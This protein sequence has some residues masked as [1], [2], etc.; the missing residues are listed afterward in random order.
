MRYLLSIALISLCFSLS[1]QETITYPYNPDADGDSFI[2]VSDILEGVATYDTEFYPLS[3]QIDSVNLIDVIQAMQAAI[4]ALET[5]NEAQGEI[6]DLLLSNTESNAAQIQ[7]LI[8]AGFIT[9]EVDPIASSAGYITEE[10]DPV[11]NASGY[12][13]EIWVEEQGYSTGSGID[14]LEEYLSVDDAN[15]TV[16]IS[17]A[18]LQV[19]SGEGNTGAAANGTGNIIIGYDEDNWSGDADKSGSHNLV[20]GIGHTYSSFGGIVV[21]YEN[22]ITGHFSSVSGGSTNTASGLRSSVSGGHG[23]TAEGSR[24]SVSGGDY[25]TASG[26]FSSVSAG[27]NNTASGYESSVSG[28]RVNTASGEM[29]SVSGGNDNTASGE[30]SSVSGGQDNTASGVASSVS[31]GNNNTASVGSSSVSGGS[32]NTA[33]GLSSSVSGG[34]GNNAFG[35]SSSVSGDISYQGWVE[36]QGYLTTETDPVATSAGYLTTETDPVAMEAMPTHLTQLSNW[37][38]ADNDG[39]NDHQYATTTDV[40][41]IARDYKYSSYFGHNNR[42]FS[43]QNFLDMNWSGAWLTGYTFID[44]WAPNSSFRYATLHEVTFENTWLTGSDFEGANLAYSTW[45]NSFP[46]N[47][48][49]DC[50]DYFQD[51]NL[52]GADF[53]QCSGYP[54]FRTFEGADMSGAIIPD[55]WENGWF[56]TPS[57]WPDGWTSGNCNDNAP[58]YCGQNPCGIGQS[59]YKWV[60]VD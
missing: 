52:T 2:G 34:L 6:I 9:E 40:L 42:T 21:G 24:S 22:S 47:G 32:T 44:T 33:S 3:I 17:G 60:K 23:N 8:D 15:K 10:L 26:D 35:P 28:G 38:D 27:Y 7:A 16:L 14:G 41:N 54:G 56:G 12:A 30:F 58:S 51:A 13:T 29:S 18:N 45:I 39:W 57:V 36:E 59:Y 1:A 31:A 46:A 20:V 53:S 25:N 4:E 49:D 55:S 37:T 50:Y 5:Q 48:W 43:N 11:A 19:V